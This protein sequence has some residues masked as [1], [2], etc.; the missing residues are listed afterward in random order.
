MKF[1]LKGTAY[2]ALIL[3]TFLILTY[4]ISANTFTSHGTYTNKNIKPFTIDSSQISHNTADASIDDGD[5]PE[6][7]RQDELKRAEEMINVKWTPKY[8]FLD[9]EGKFIFIKG[10]TYCGIP[11]SM[12]SFQASSANDFLKKINTDKNLYGNDCS[13]F[14]SAAW[15][16]KRQTTYTFLSAVKNGG[17]VGGFPLCEISWNN[18]KPGD[19]LL[20]DDG[21]GNGHVMMFVG[22][23]SK[24]NDKLY[25]YEQNVSTI[26]PF[27][28]IPAA[29]EDQRSE[30]TL[31]DDGYIPVRLIKNK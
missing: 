26:V 17:D 12:G 9:K 30:K 22:M 16:I 18:L 1:I 13:G 10:K 11:Y 28:P 29:R 6:S 27:E 15:G 7:V 14:I 20:L 25:V 19:G 5:I 3:M 24:D 21:K 8:N 23:D 4:V 2:T 31:K